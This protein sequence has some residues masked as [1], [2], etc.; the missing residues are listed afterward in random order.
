MNQVSFG[1]YVLSGLEASLVSAP[2]S[3]QLRA[4]RQHR[5]RTI[6]ATL[7][8]RSMVLA[9]HHMKVAC[10]SS[11]AFWQQCPCVAW[12]SLATCKTAGGK[13]RLELF[14]PEDYP[15]AAPK[16]LQDDIELCSLAESFFLIKHWR[17]LTGPIF[18]KN[19]PSQHR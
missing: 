4:S 6:C 18:D 16:V 11:R 10:P 3:L 14:L 7:M 5:R 15:M 19:L 8:L 9:L 13:F 12:Y 1:L 17:C 2:E